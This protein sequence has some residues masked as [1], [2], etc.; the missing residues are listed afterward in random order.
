MLELPKGTILSIKSLKII[1]P[2]KKIALVLHTSAVNFR[3]E[4]LAELKE[5]GI[6]TYFP[7]D[8]LW[9]LYYLRNSCISEFAKNASYLYNT[10]NTTNN[11][12]FYL[13]DLYRG[14]NKRFKRPDDI[15]KEDIIVFLSPNVELFL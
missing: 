3:Y 9:E 11:P 1:N 6:S 13:R 2:D 15:F 14:D 10:V 5:L 12:F 7:N 4:D 8:T